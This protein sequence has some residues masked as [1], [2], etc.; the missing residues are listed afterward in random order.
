MAKKPGAATDAAPEGSDESFFS[1]LLGR[2]G[3]DPDDAEVDPDAPDTDDTD[4]LVAFLTQVESNSRSQEEAEVRK[5]LEG[6]P[7]LAVEEP[8]S[9]EAGVQRLLADRADADEADEILAAFGAPPP[10]AAPPPEPPP[11]APAT[12]E[13]PMPLSL[14]EVRGELASLAEPLPEPAPGAGPHPLSMRDLFGIEAEPLAE[15]PLP[16]PPDLGEPMAPRQLAATRRLHRFFLEMV[17]GRVK[18]ELLRYLVVT[19]L[20]RLSSRELADAL[21]HAEAPVKRALSELERDGL[22]VAEG[23]RFGLNPRS[24][25]VLL[26]ATLVAAWSSPERRAEI[27]G[28]LDG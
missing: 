3:G 8:L 12:R 2:F 20:E 22:V 21:H 24:R 23:H 17:G 26:V 27:E 6:L 16:P 1:E 13:P 9:A 18:L 28:W 11:E 19:G 5:L 15:A 25:N 14:E 7:G 4:E 10:A